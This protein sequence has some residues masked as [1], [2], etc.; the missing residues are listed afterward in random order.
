M[1]RL[2]LHFQNITINQLELM[3]YLLRCST[4]IHPRNSSEQFH[5]NNIHVLKMLCKVRALI[6]IFFSSASIDSVAVRGLQLVVTNIHCKM[7]FNSLVW[8]RRISFPALVAIIV[9]KLKMGVNADISYGSLLKVDLNS[10]SQK[11][12]VGSKSELGI[13]TDR[14]NVV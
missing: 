9:C 2:Y 8:R 12:V 13:K 4:Q 14:V 3:L 7:L 11:S 5:T 6:M 10:L 1:A